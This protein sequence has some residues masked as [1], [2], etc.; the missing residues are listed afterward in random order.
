MGVFIC[1]EKYKR[2]IQKIEKII[3]LVISLLYNDCSSSDGESTPPWLSQLFP[4][5]FPDLFCL[6]QVTGLPTITNGHL[7][8]GDWLV[9]Y[10]KGSKKAKFRQ[11]AKMLLSLRSN[12]QTM[13]P[14]IQ[15]CNGLYTRTDY[16]MLLPI[17]LYIIVP[18]FLKM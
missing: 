16:H 5:V 1:L 10:S 9:W 14:Y 13:S 11:A 7:L 4:M 3:N 15:N 18:L 2:S 6:C 12:P 17:V 8:I